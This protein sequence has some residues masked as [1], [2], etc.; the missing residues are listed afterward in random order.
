MDAD[1]LMP[2]LKAQGSSSQLEFPR[3]V[4]IRMGQALSWG[5][6]PV[7]GQCELGFRSALGLMVMRAMFRVRIKIRA[8]RA[9]FNVRIKIRVMRARCRVRIRIR[10][11]A[12]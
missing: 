11:N 12:S 1:A 5:S 7:Y 4:Y 2:T 9:R 3:C 8:M 10:G 6:G